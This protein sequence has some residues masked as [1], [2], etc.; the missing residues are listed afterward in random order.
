ME[1]KKASDYPQELLDLFHEY[2]H[3]EITRRDFL[4]RAQPPLRRQVIH[5]A[6]LI[7]VPELAPV[8]TVGTMLPA[9]RHQLILQSKT[10]P[11]VAR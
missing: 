8:G 3:G 7:V 11:N 2:Q 1:R 5:A 9:F 10:A 6:A 4:E